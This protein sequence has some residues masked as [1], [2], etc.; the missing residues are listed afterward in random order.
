MAGGIFW[1]DKVRERNSS[2]GLNVCSFSLPPLKVCDAVKNTEICNIMV[3][4]HDIYLQAINYPTVPRGEE[5]LRL[6]PSPR[7]EPEMMDHFVG[8]SRWRWTE[9]E[10]GS[11]LATHR[12][13]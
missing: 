7:H 1:K 13:V 6:A 4:Q 12:G 2:P 11:P 3:R 9:G 8:E 5:L 10:P